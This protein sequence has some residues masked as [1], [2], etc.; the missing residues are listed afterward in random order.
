[1][2][3][4]REVRYTDAMKLQFPLQ[5]V[6]VI[7]GAFLT[8]AGGMWASTYG[9]RS[10][11]RDILTR[12]ELQTQVDE[13]RAKVQEERIAAMRESIEAMKRR[14]ELQQYELQGMKEVLLTTKPRGQKP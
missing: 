1:M 13:A 6:F 10:D 8:C 9:L 5:F 2:T 3:P 12:M 14:Q 11:V 4:P 7:V